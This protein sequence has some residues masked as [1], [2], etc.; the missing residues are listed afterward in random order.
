MTRRSKKRRKKWEWLNKR[1]IINNFSVTT[2]RKRLF[3]LICGITFIFL[4]ILGRMFYVNVV[5]G[6]ELRVKAID[7]WTRELPV[8]ALRG[9]I[10]DANGTVIA[11]NKTTYAVYVRTRCVKNP[12]KTASVLSGLFSVDESKLL[13]KIKTQSSSEITVKRQVGKDEVLKLEEYELDG[14]YYSIDNG[15]VYH[16]GSSL[17]QTVGYTSVDGRGIC[18]LEAYYDKFLK[19]EN[20]EIIF[21]ADLVGADVEGSTP[22]YKPARNGLSIKLSVDME[23]QLI[24]ESALEKAAAQYTPKSCSIIVMNPKNGR[25]VAM[26]NNP[27]FDLNSPPRED[28]KLLNALSRNTLVV[29]SY[30]PGSTFKIVTALAD[31]EETLKGNERALSLT[32]VFNSSNYRIVDGRKIKC[33]TTHA[34]GKHANETLSE[35]LNNSCNPCFVDIALSLG[36]EKMYEYVSGLNFG[37]ATGIDFMGEATGMVL[38]VGSVRDGD[39]ARIS[40]GQTIAVTPLQLAA[41]ACACVNGGNYYTPQLV[42][43]IYDES[44]KIAEI[45]EPDLKNKVASEEASKILARYL[46][47][48]VSEGSGKNAYVEGYRVGGKTGTAQKFENGSI[49]RGKY[50]MSFMGFFPANDPEYLALAIVDEPVGGN[51]GS[52]VAAPIVK[53]VFE[54][55]INCKNISVVESA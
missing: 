49:A 2:V 20:G 28:I 35:A 27:S 34:G 40:F 21:E 50:V 47:R 42:T 43:E 26:A 24:C 6:R 18:G 13:E 22:H 8:T 36:K 54:K 44:T 33:W 23:I 39:I 53:E 31:I 38:P 7:Q 12:E 37:S 29:D 17:C 5:W 41:A 4:L 11:G 9:Q 19:G 32:H 14:V 25:I 51:Y 30:E 45:I 55:I 46:E 10:V 48:V 1:Y 3:S 52:T 16:F 15:R